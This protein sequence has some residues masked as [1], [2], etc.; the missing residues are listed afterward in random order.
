MDRFIQWLEENIKF[1]EIALFILGAFWF[2]HEVNSTLQRPYILG[3]S[4]MMMYPALSR[5]IL[6]VLSGGGNGNGKGRGGRGS[7]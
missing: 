1:R 6:G 7:E 2:N 3:L 5:I 4:A